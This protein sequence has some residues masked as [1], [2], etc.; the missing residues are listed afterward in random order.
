V[1]YR[2]ELAPGARRAIERDLPE[3]VAAA[4]WEFIIGPLASDP[5]RVGKPL[6]GKLEGRW[7]ARRGS[8][9]VIYTI[10]NVDVL[11]MV[12]RVAHR[13]DIYYS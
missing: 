1:T 13:S 10:N 8:Y 7:S 6:M 5:R 2:I 3:S 9:R 11:V 4:A 12:L